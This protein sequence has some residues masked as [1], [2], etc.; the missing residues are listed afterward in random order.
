MALTITVLLENRRAAGAETSLQAKPG[1]SLLVQD[2]TTTILFDTGPD[3]SFKLNAA[4][5]GVD[6]SQLTATVLSHGHYDH[7]GG[8]SWLADNTRVIC[9][10]Q[11]AC[12]RYS[13]ISLFG[14]TSKI[15]KLSRDNDYSRL[16]MEYTQE[17]L[18]ISER[19]LWSGEISVPTPRA[20]GV[21]RERTMRQDYIADEG[22]LIYKSDRGLVI[23]TGCGHRGIENIVR[24]C[25]NITGITKIHA[26]I[27][28]FH[29][30]C[31]SPY[32]LWQVRQFLNQ[33]KPERLLGCH[34]TGSWGRLWLPE[35]SAPATGDVIVLE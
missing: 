4:L 35:I 23:I 34:C 7:C 15:K 1:L 30:R 24:H 27:G 19:F 31:A 10:P 17:P 29:L 21:I 32:K 28:G 5:M 20:Y 25:Q 2:E 14:Y 9:H 33:Q 11:I 26:L 16:S 12:E 13:A 8:V 22:V 18:S 3:D 6:L